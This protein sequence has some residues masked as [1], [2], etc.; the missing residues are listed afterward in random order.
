MVR[1]KLSDMEIKLINST[2]KFL[3]KEN[4]VG[5]IDLANWAGSTII[6]KD[7]ISD[8]VV[9]IYYLNDANEG[10][11][12]ILGDQKGQGKKYKESYKSFLIKEIPEIK[13]RITE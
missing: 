1:D 10:D 12:R 6:V 4:L 8:S 11:I 3:K 13:D 9:G 2:L 7:C 5:S